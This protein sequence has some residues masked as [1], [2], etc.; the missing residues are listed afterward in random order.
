[1]YYQRFCN[2]RRARGRIVLGASPVSAE[3]TLKFA[4]WLPPVHLG[5]QQHESFQDSVE[6]A[7]AA[8]LKSKWTKARFKPPGQFDLAVNGVRDIMHGCLYTRPIGFLMAEIPLQQ[9]M[10]LLA[11]KA[12]T[13]G[14][15]KTALIKRNSKR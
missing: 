10:P 2:C 12:F 13:N 15:W 3:T 11:A 6:A 1:M 14:M 7:A 5:R 4:N 9:K 8:K